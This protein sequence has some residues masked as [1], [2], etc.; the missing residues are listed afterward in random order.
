MTHGTFEKQTVG[1]R[2]ETQKHI[3]RIGRRQ[4]FFD[5]RQE[6]VWFQGNAQK[7]QKDATILRKN[8]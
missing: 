4:K 7:L 2:R 3:F 1:Q 8:A 6:I 5:Q